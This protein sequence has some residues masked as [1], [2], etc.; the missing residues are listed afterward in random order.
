MTRPVQSVKNTLFARKV[1]V[2]NATL[3]VELSKIVS[4]Y[5]SFVVTGLKMSMS[6]GL[7]YMVIFRDDFF[8]VD[9]AFRHRESL[10]LFLVNSK[11][12]S[13]FVTGTRFVGTLRVFVPLS[14]AT[15]AGTKGVCHYTLIKSILPGHTAYLG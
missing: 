9:F 2:L 15:F 6:R 3:P 10:V 13:L 12:M 5:T 1:C 14:C 11:V 8:E 4:V 7:R